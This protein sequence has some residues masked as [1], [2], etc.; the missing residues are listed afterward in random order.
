M[1]YA[2]GLDPAT[3]FGWG[4]LAEQPDGTWLPDG[5]GTMD[6][7]P[8]KEEPEGVRFLRIADWIPTVLDGV[9]VAIFEQPFSKG[10]RTAQILFGIAAV[11]LVELERREIPYMWVAPTTLKKFATGSGGSKKNPV[12]K[13]MV[14]AALNGWGRID[15]E[16]DMSL[17]ASD[18]LTAARYLVETQLVEPEPELQ[19]DF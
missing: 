16:T 11:C 14:R 12:T 6:F 17:D 8:K 9:D 2:L 19:L 13:E 1:R 5:W 3:S 7:S 4:L 18:A 15:Y 10:Y